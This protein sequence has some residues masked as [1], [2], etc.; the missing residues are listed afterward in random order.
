MTKHLALAA[1]FAMLVA[2]SG[3]ALAATA[4]PNGQYWSEA[5]D[6]A[7]PVHIV[8]AFDAA[9]PAQPV[10]NTHRYEGGPKSND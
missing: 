7:Q 3:Q 8:G 10:S 2:T 9:M 1:S 4:T 6:R 5:T